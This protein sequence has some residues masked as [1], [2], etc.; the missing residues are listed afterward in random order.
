MKKMK[1]ISILFLL[2][3]LLFAQRNDY[4]K[5]AGYVNFGDLE[6]FERGEEVTEVIIEE[7]LLKMVAKMTIHNEPEVSDLISGLKLVKVN[8]F[9]VTDETY[10]QLK[11]KVE[12]VDKDLMAKGWD[13]I[14][15][16]R[17]KWEYVNVYIRTENEDMITG[18]VVASIENHGEAAFVN[19]VGD[20]DL[21]SIGKLGAKF[22]VPGL[23]SVTVY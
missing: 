22:D 1:L 6:S 18:L 16:T 2:S 17:S 9:E 8:T 5:Y 23:D 20:I 15:K 19:I 7:H 4:S 10:P 12:S 3:T 13:R 21:E 11:S 14:V